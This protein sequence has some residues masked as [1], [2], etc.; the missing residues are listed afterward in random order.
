MSVF[1]Q[2]VCSLNPKGTPEH[3]SRHHVHLVEQDEAPLPASDGVKDTLT[4]LGPLE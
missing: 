1:T 4:F 2:Q 3:L